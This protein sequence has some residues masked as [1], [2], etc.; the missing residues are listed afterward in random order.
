MYLSKLLIDPRN[1]QAQRDLADRYE[2]HRTLVR[3]YA[4]DDTSMPHRHL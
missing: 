1:A 2:M 4:K 3:V